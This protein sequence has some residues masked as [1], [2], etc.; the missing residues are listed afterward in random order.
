MSNSSPQLMLFSATC[1]SEKSHFKGYLAGHT[2]FT[3]PLEDKESKMA[4][5]T[6]RQAEQFVIESYA[7]LTS[8]YSYFGSILRRRIAA[9]EPTSFEQESTTDPLYGQFL[10]PRISFPCN[11]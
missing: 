9:Y 7:L 2:V 1:K 5:T 6:A 4:S 8:G 3:A 10:Y 11:D